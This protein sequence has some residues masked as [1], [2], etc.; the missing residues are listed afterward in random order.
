[1]STIRQ[2]R[3]SGLVKRDL[4]LI[5]Q[6]EAQTLG[7]GSMVS[8]TSVRVTPDLSIAKVYLSIFAAKDKDGVFKNIQENAK[9]IR[10]QLSQRIKTQLRKTPEL[11]FYID[12]SLDYAEKI[13][14]LLQ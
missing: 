7:L 14:Q 2:D 4:S 6:Q 1:M 9:N 5:F 3:I 12:D 11:V 10:H 8:V 13:D